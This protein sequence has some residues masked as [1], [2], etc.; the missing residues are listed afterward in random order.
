MQKREG[1]YDGFRALASA[2][3][4]KERWQRR[5]AGFPAV[6]ERLVPRVEPGPRYL[7]RELE[8]SLRFPGTCGS[9]LQA[10]GS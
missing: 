4:A 5:L 8:L 6:Y 3:G 1:V 7:S 10:S 2:G 9:I